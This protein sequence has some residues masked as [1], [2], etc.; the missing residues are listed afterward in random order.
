M[1]RVAE[2]R[3]R[4]GNLAR[5][6]SDRSWRGFVG[7]IAQIVKGMPLW[8]LQTLRRQNVPFLYARSSGPRITLLPGVAFNLRRFGALIQLL[9]RSAWLE[10]IRSN[11]RNAPTVGGASD[12][13]LFLFG[14]ARVDLSAARAALPG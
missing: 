1:A 3:G 5:A 4:F 14:G 6:K 2:A 9:A 8:K 13:E 7:S 12:L 11:P 10:H